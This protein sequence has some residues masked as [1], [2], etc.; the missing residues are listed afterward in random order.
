MGR[1]K[2]HDINI[3]REHILAKREN[4]HLSLIASQ[5]FFKISELNQGFSSHTWGQTFKNTTRPGNSDS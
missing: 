4:A 1:L 2:L 5:R 3:P